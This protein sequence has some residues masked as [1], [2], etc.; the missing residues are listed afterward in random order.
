MQ[1][2]ARVPRG[3]GPSRGGPMPWRHN[4]SAH[5]DLDI[6]VPFQPMA[7]LLGHASD[8]LLGHFCWESGG[9]G[10]GSVTSWCKLGVM[11][12]PSLARFGQSLGTWD[13]PLGALGT[14]LRFAQLT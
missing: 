1:G 14:I 10:A 6:W 2:E 8:L 13:P 11:M 5:C 12:V 3:L 4:V 7:V 9:W